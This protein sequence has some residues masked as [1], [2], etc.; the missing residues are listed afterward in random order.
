MISS[1]TRMSTGPVST[2]SS[3]ARASGPVNPSITSC[4]SPVSS[5]A[6]TRAEKTSP[7]DSMPSLARNEGQ[8]LGRGPVQPLRVIHHANERAI[9]CGLRQQAQHSQADQEPV[10]HRIIVQPKSDPKRLALRSRQHL[11][12]IED[13]CAQLVQRRERE[14]HLPLDGRDANDAA[15][16][17]SLCQVLQQRCLAHP[18]LAADH[19]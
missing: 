7:T 18:R 4:G 14:L 6:G 11:K 2:V 13:G 10:R 3:N 8:D 12:S 15:V 16:R 17:S 1:R 19:Q 5:S 9:F